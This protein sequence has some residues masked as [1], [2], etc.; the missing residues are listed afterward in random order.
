MQFFNIKK[1]KKLIKV[2][3]IF[4][5]EKVLKCFQIC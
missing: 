5:L 3:M 2:F 1:K 4:L